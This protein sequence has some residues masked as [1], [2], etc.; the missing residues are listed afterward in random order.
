MSYSKKV[1]EKL[2]KQKVKIGNEISMVIGSKEYNGILLDNSEKESDILIVKLNN[3]YNVGLEINDSIKFIGEGYSFKNNESSDNFFNEDNDISILTFGGTIS[4]K[5]EYK[6]GA[7][8][9]SISNKEFVEQFPEINNFGKVNFKNVFS[10]LSEDINISHWKEMG[11][12]IYNELKNNKSVVATHGTDTMSYSSSA[13]SF[14]IQNP[15]K[16]VVFTGSQRSSDRGSSDNKENLLNSVFYAQSGLPGIYVCMHRHSN[17]GQG[18]IINGVNAR[19]MHTSKRDAFKSINTQPVA[20]IDYK[21]KSLE[22][23]ST[24]KKNENEMKL[25]D[26]FNENVAM[27]YIHPGIKPSFISK[28]SD[29]DGVVLMGTGLGHVP[30]NPYNNE[31]SLSIFNEIKDLINSEIPVVM[32]PQTIHGRLNLN[33]YT[34]GRMLN[35]IGVIGHL[36]D[37]TPETAYVKLSWVL[38]QTKE[39]KKVKEMMH[40][41]YC[42]EFS[43]HTI[44]ENEEV[45]Q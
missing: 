36:C 31:K 40:T 34:S 27:V 22:Y 17:D 32:A 18:V 3:G 12:E 37:W 8:Y 28:L 29:Y 11:K 1:K 41:N 13:L 7:V 20:Y 38:G 44:Y 14:M 5:V 19:K 35:E 10:L 16:P 42:S 15:I 45:E 30:T 43:E 24:P 23:V 39:M 26:K 4:S 25:I 33:V 2:E 9:P 6:T 21:S